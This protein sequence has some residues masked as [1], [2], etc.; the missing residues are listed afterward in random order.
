MDNDGDGYVVH[1]DFDCID[2]DGD[3]DGDGYCDGNG[4][5]E[6]VADCY[7]YDNCSDAH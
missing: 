6:G 2:D 5:P 4:F 3:V 7:C 1:G